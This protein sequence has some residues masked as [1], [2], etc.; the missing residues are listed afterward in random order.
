[1][2]NLKGLR[3]EVFCCQEWEAGRPLEEGAGTGRAVPQ[4]NPFYS[5]H[6]VHDRLTLKQT[7]F[8]ASQC[9]QLGGQTVSLAS[10]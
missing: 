8:G 6:P 9:Y 5:C 10:I 2:P 1:M 7:P 4:R 3:G